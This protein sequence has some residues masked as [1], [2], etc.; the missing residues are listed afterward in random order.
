MEYELYYYCTGMGTLLI[1]LIIF[2]HA[3]SGEKG[4]TGDAVSDQV[5]NKQ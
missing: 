3:I 2:Y 5:A 4:Y 1:F